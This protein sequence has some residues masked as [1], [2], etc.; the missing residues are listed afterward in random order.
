MTMTTSNKRLQWIN[1]ASKA[2]RPKILLLGSGGLSI[3]QAGE[4]DYSGTQA[5]KGFV[6]D[7]FEVIVVNP[8]IATVQTNPIENVRVYLYPVTPEWVTKVIEEERPVAIAGGFGGQTALN[9]LVKL[10]EL[11]VV[12][13]YNLSVLGSP[14]DVLKLT[15]D[16]DEFATRMKEI[17]IPTPPSFAC[18]NYKSAEKAAHDIGYPVIVR[19]AFALG[20]LGSGFASSDEELQEIVDKALKLSPQ[21]LVEK[22]FK[23]WKEVEYEV[24]RDEAENV[25][26]ICNMENFDPLGIHTGDSIVVCPSQSL[27]DDEYQLLRNSSI[28][29]VSNIGVIGECN[30]QFALSPD[31]LEFYVIEVN[32]R[33]SRSSALASKASGYPIAYIASKVVLG[34]SLLDLT[35]PVTGIT[36]AFFEP[37]L[38]YIT[39]KIPRW[40]LPK[41]S[42]V[43]RHLGSTMKSVGEIMSI[44]RS[45][46]EALQK[47]VR[48]VKEDA[49]GLS[50]S[51][52]DPMPKPADVETELQFPTDLRLYSVMDA[53]RLGFDIEK[54]HDLTKIDKWFLAEMREISVYEKKVLESG[55]NMTKD[56]PWSEA[57]A[58]WAESNRELLQTT[59]QLGFSDEQLVLILGSRFDAKMPSETVL[60][61]RALDLRAARKQQGI[62]PHPKRI[63]TTA[64]EYPAE[65]NYMYFSYGVSYSDLEPNAFKRPVLILGGGSYR[66][67]TSVEFDWCAVTCSE[68]LRSNG[69]SSVILNCNPETVSTDFNSSD[70]L[71]FD[72]VSL[73]RILD[74]IELVGCEG[75]VA[76]MGGQLPNKLVAPLSAANVKLL[77]HSAD[78][79]DRAEN[80]SRFSKIL[81]SLGVEQ[82]R[83]QAVTTKEELDRF[84]ERVGYPLL[85]RPSYVLSGAAMRVAYDEESLTG[86]LKS[87]TTLSPDYPLVVSEFLE[88]AREIELDGVASNGRVLVSIVSEHVENAGV[89]SGDATTVVPAQNLYVETVRRVKSAG[90]KIAEGLGLNGPFNIQFLAKEGDVKVIECN[91]RAA[92]S[93]PFISKVVGLNLAEVATRVM[94]G[95]AADDLKYFREDHLP[96]VGVKA[97]MFSFT[98]LGGADPVLGVEMASTGEVGCIGED[99]DEALLLSLEASHITIPHKG[100]LVSSGGE[101]SKL[102]FL[103]SAR[104]LQKLN[105]PIYAT[106]GTAAYLR[107]HGFENIASVPW[108]SS[109]ENNPLELIRNGVVDLVI[110]VPKSHGE[111][112]LTWG[113]RIRRTSADVGCPL[114]TNIEKANAFIHAIQRSEHIRNSKR[115]Y[116]LPPYHRVAPS[117]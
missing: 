53:F 69:Y 7:G 61:K 31:S 41:F 50:Y 90:E 106:E 84:T 1:G 14:V 67:G 111:K 40:D 82:P 47:A 3:G 2:V 26:T 60:W 85:V 27:S 83:W 59:K 110:N 38:D 96:Y 56:Q 70:L 100:V 9:C 68:T 54:V 80:R 17:G 89:H 78:T 5:V 55:H 45:F 64:G 86:F 30:V 57:M 116:T 46:P 108:S 105:I 87:A 32:A 77:G 114:L 48:M 58:L 115:L 79:V 76:S 51:Y 113:A 71:F 117:R 81:D 11:G 94:I 15:E 74:V 42:G 28:H 22:S 97:A 107:N 35:N 39:M 37:A 16:R 24:M 4:F 12:A 98:R 92:R 25:I 65:T 44:A 34:H 104:I 93:F 52:L 102:K 73:E 101:K 23:G 109:K 36:K 20:G 49:L 66:I 63:D 75:V 72:E 33:L 103:K 29:I 112:E 88:D 18:V 13:K 10:D 95:N 6:E 8:N 99:F 62:V 91:A 43:S 19:A 21:V